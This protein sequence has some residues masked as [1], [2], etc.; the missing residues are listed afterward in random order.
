M[1][2][3]ERNPSRM[4]SRFPVCVPSW[5]VDTFT[6]IGTTG[7]QQICEKDHELTL[8]NVSLEGFLSPLR[9]SK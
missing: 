3:E 9:D 1:G 2:S 5:V 7:R 4:I 8:K 6:R